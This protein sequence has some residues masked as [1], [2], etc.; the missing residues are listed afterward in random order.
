MMGALQQH[1]D[2][3]DE[4]VAHLKPTV[5]LEVTAE[6]PLEAHV[7]AM[8][9]LQ[10]EIDDTELTVESVE[11]EGVVPNIGSDLQQMFGGD[12][13]TDMF[14]PPEDTEMA[15]DEDL[16]VGETANVGGGVGSG[17]AD[18]NN[19]SSDDSTDE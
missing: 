5:H 6:S 14:E 12:V 1:D 4:Y 17:G 18:A 16:S 19:D 13:E 11:I 3:D 10:S 9:Q 8:Q 7:A 2:G 15:V